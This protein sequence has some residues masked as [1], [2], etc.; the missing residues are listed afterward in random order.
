MKEEYTRINTDTEF[1]RKKILDGSYKDQY[2]QVGANQNQGIKV[3]IKETKWDEDL[4][5]SKSQATTKTHADGTVGASVVEENNSGN[6]EYSYNTDIFTVVESVV[7]AE[8][9]KNWR[10]TTMMI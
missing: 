8:T 3:S 4:Y 2:L 10:R 9:G 6:T 1:N 7:I 5:L